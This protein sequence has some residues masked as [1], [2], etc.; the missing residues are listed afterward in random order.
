MR[1]FIKLAICGRIKNLARYVKTKGNSKRLIKERIINPFVSKYGYLIVGLSKNGEEKK[2]PVHRL[3][4]EAFIP[5]P[6]NKPEVNHKFG[7]K[8]D[9]RASQLEWNTRS[10]NEQHAYNTGLIKLR[11]GERHQNSKKV[12]QFDLQGVFI[13]EWSFI[14]EAG[15]EL[16]INR[17]NITQCC[18]GNYKTAGGYIW[19]YKDT[20]S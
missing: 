15:K 5:N 10:E 2:Y 13:K 9:N 14:A 20:N 11:C 8:L 7:I 17:S 18:K 16:N 19:K 3:V 6:E 1:G 4:A 12:L